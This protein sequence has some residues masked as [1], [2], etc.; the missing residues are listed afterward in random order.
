VGI[1]EEE[2]L[3]CHIAGQKKED[4]QYTYNRNNEARSR[5]HCCRGEATSITYFECVFAALVIP[6]AKRMR[7]VI[8]SS[9]EFPAL[10]YFST[11]FYKRHDFRKKVTEHKM[12]V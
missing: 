12:C 8:L 5:N 2:F 7:S 10:P 4:T 11:L 3:K 1:H 6:H 9:M